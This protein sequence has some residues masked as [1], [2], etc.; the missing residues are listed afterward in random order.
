MSLKK[1]TRT[2]LS[3]ARSRESSLN[4]KHPYFANQ[5]KQVAKLFKRQDRKALKNYML[6]L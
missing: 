5:R 6:G 2:L 1:T 4:K 3:H